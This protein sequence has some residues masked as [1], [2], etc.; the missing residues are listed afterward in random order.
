M[1]KFR[2]RLLISIITLIV[3]VLIGLGLLLGQL[4]KSYYLKSFNERLKIES[5]VLTSYIEDNGG[6]GSFD[7]HKL[8]SISR[9]LESR[10]TISDADGTILY[11]SGERSNTKIREHAEIIREIIEKQPEIKNGYEV[12]RG[13]DL[14]Y[15]WSP[16]HKDGKKEGYVFLS[17]QIDELKKIYRQIWM[18]LTASLG[19]ALVVI[20]F[21]V[22]RITTRYT[23]PIESA[24]NVAIE[25]AK[26][27][28]LARTYEDHMDETGMLSAS[29]NV[30]ARNLQ[31]LMK[32]QEMQQDRLTTLIENM[33][34]GL[35]LIDSKGYINL[36][37]RA[38]KEIFNVNPSDYLY[39]LYYEVIEHQ[40]ISKLIEEIFM[41]EQKI[42][43]QMLIPL[44][45]ERRHFEVYG[46][47]IIGT[48]DVWKG[49]LLVFHDITELKRLEQMRKDFVANVSH[50][51]KTPITSIKGFTETLL[52]GAMN[53]KN[54]LEA[55]LNIILQESGRLQTLI[56]DLLDLSK[57]EQQGFKLNIQTVDL[58]M[59]LNDVITILEGKAN[60]KGISLMLE[61]SGEHIIVEGDLY[62]LKQIFINLIN[63]AITYTPNGG[64]VTVKIIENKKTV[65]A[66][67][68]DTGIGI[69]K[70]EIPR[71]FE[72]FY[73]V[74]KAR[75]R[76]SG[77]TGLGLAI[78]KH[79]VEAH[80]GNISVQSQFGKGTEFTI[81]FHKTLQL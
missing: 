17:T 10:I 80:K 18:L 53:D 45:I 77:G 14:R 8:D 33:G 12:K 51:L 60:E 44:A 37:N 31:E 58:V 35:I 50:E 47:P 63:N 16:I 72:R 29:I 46:A 54:T 65:T 19:M 23:K 32:T 75:S 66:K 55:F 4:F 64:M 9:M 7:G 34:S 73:R 5:D 22:S 78:V 20:I 74:D 56:Q 38:Y 2:T 42:K 26:G 21:L 1:I 62:R 49:I 69:N 40:E 61:T 36:I 70:D 27:N 13:Y 25:L 30:L 39:R 3:T 52:D 41:T 57:I 68:K 15:Y 79:L 48:N 76:N 81:E 6:I 24:T 59:M 43:K 67:V 28:Y 11:D 71:I